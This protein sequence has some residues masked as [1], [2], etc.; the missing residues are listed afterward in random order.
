MSNLQDDRI[1]AN[2]TLGQR[3]FELIQKYSEMRFG[4]ILVNFEFVSTNP[5]YYHGSQP[6]NW[7]DEFYLEPMELLKRVEAAIKKASQ[8]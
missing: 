8:N 6:H 3:L 1:A 7:S 5:I 4:Q 2:I